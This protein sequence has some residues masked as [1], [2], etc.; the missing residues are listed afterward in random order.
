M[1]RCPTAAA[2]GRIP[3]PDSLC[4]Q[5]ALDLLEFVTGPPDSQWGSRR[6]AMGRSAPWHLNYLAIG[7][8]V[9]I[10]LRGLGGRADATCDLRLASPICQRL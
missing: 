1:G 9:G 2:E 8:E 10:P 6:V 4:C 7:N 5:D 3:E